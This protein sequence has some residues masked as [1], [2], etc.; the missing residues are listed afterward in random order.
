[1]MRR[2]PTPHASV[3]GQ[4][5][6]LAAGGGGRPGAAAGGSVDYA[7]QRP[8]RHLDAMLEPGVE[9]FKPPCVHAD[10]AAPIALPVAN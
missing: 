2:E 7:E 9:L 1:M 6:Q 3:R 4:P 5:A 10:L 8:D